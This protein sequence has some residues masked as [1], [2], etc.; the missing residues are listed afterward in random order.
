MASC[1]AAVAVYDRP[2]DSL[3]ALICAL[4]T[5]NST[6]DI[7][8]TGLSGLLQRRL[9]VLLTSLLFCCLLK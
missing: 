7:M 3:L 8:M 5:S 1:L 9:E 4:V 6:T 2:D